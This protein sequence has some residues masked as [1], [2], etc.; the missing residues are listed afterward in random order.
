MNS[1]ASE[2][3]SGVMMIFFSRSLSS[4]ATRPVASEIGALPLG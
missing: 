4:I 1:A 2:P 3:S